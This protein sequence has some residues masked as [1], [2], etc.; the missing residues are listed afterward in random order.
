MVQKIT[1][2]MNHEQQRK[3]EEAMKAAK[4]KPLS[5]SSSILARAHKVNGAESLEMKRKPRP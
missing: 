2:Q 1:R 4:F 3:I 5:D